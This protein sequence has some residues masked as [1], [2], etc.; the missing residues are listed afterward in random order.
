MKKTT[1]HSELIFALND[2]LFI[3]A[4]EGVTDEQAKERISDHNNPLIWIAAH[5]LFARYNTL[6]MLGSTVQNPYG[7]QFANFRPYDPADQFPSLDA[8]KTEW[9]KVASQLKDAFAAVTEEHLAAD[10]PLKSPIG[11]F[12]F[13]GTIAFL[14]SHECYDIGQMAFLKKYYTNSPMKYN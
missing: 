3:S 13:A 5:T 4:L 14:A 10:C 1:Y 9:A 2:R 11:D 7:E 8:I 6:S 12:S